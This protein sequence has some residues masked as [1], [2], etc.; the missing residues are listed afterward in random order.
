MKIF[1]LSLAVFL[2]SSA[3]ADFS[4]FKVNIELDMK[5]R[6]R[7]TRELVIQEKQLARVNM[8]EPNEK[9]LFVELFPFMRPRSSKIVRIQGGLFAEQDSGEI[10]LLASPRIETKLSNAD[11]RKPA[12]W[13]VKSL[14]SPEFNVRIEIEDYDSDPVFSNEGDAIYYSRNKEN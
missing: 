6:K 5:G 1:S 13:N 11:K 8:A 7:V 3:F 14:Y 12:S 4:F 9:A 2:S 10:K